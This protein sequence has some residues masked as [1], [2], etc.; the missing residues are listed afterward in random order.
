LYSDIPGLPDELGGVKSDR[1]WFIE[2]FDSLPDA[3][4]DEIGM[5]YITRFEL[6][7]F[8]YKFGPLNLVLIDTS[9]NVLSPTKKMTARENRSTRRGQVSAGVLGGGWT[10]KRH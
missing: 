6:L 2:I 3:R 4:K 10:R 9:C 1:D 7:D 8:F 5:P